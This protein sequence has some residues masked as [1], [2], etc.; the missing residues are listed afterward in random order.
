MYIKD[1]KFDRWCTIMQVCTPA[2]ATV[3][4]SGQ[5]LDE[6]VTLVVRSVRLSGG[7]MNAGCSAGYADVTCRELHLEVTIQLH[8]DSSNNT[9]T[10]KHCALHLRSLWL[11]EWVV[12][13]AF[14]TSV[15]SAAR[16]SRKGR[17]TWFTFAAFTTSVSRCAVGS[18][19]RLASPATACSLIIGKSALAVVATRIVQKWWCVLAI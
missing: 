9:E 6:C 18:V 16:S 19:A 4:E 3:L 1:V 8:F 17:T 5:Y 7:V 14:S 10:Q 13:A 15:S 2:N 11:S 12:F